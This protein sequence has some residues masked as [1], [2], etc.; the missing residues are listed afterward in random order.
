MLAGLIVV[1]IW[2]SRALPDDGQSNTVGSVK[3]SLFGLAE[4]MTEAI[5]AIRS[6]PPVQDAAANGF[7]ALSRA[8]Q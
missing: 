5:A 7:R 2:W 6:V 8:D 4:R 3:M 1:K